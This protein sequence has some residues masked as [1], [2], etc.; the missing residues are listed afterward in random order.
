MKCP[1][2]QL[3]VKPAQA[4]FK[5][6]GYIYGFQSVKLY[7]ILH[8]FYMLLLT[9][10]LPFDSIGMAGFAVFREAPKG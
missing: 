9:T 5:V 3:G 1:T 6:Q 8:N 2:K 4:V 7:F 10:G